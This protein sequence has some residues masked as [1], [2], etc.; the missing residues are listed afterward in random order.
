MRRISGT[1]VNLVVNDMENMNGVNLLC[2]AAV[3]VIVLLFCYGSAGKVKKFT[4]IEAIRNG[5][6][7]ERYKVKSIIRLHN[8]KKCRPFFILPAMMY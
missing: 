8:R 7:G 5:N 2:A 4:A 3:V 1:P 6:N